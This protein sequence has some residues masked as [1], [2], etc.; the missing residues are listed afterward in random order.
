MKLDDNLV[1]SREGPPFWA[2]SL[3]DPHSHTLRQK[4]RERLCCCGEPGTKCPEV[5][6]EGE[7]GDIVVVGERCPACDRSRPFSLCSSLR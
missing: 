2:S 3:G 6:G 7:S 4:V 5:G 1:W